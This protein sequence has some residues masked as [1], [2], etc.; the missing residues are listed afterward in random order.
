MLSAG[1]VLT[2]MLAPTE[3]FRQYARMTQQ[4]VVLWLWRSDLDDVEL[5]LGLVHAYMT[6]WLLRGARVVFVADTLALFHTPMHR[7]LP[8]ARGEGDPTR[9]RSRA[10]AVGSGRCKA[11]SRPSRRDNDDCGEF[12][13]FDSIVDFTESGGGS[14]TV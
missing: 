9:G 10:V 6:A 12:I 3:A 14:Q 8:A 4:G 7:S 13:H 1:V 2:D 5:V 11:C